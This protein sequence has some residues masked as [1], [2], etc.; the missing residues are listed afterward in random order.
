MISTTAYTETSASIRKRVMRARSMQEKRFKGTDINFN[1]QLTGISVEKY[2]S[3]RES[4]KS[5]IRD[6]FKKKD[7]SAR[8]YHRI[9]KTAR[10]IADLEGVENIHD[11][12]VM[13]ALMFRFTQEEA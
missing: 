6:A 5:L 11:K 13:E 4:S 8:S 12:H 7:F 10:T 3:L 9:L 1:S 2:C